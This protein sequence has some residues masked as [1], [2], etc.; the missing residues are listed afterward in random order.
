VLRSVIPRN[1][2]C[3]NSISDDDQDPERDQDQNP[4]SSHLKLDVAVEL[5][6]P[7]VTSEIELQMWKLFHNR[8]HIRNTPS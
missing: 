7:N 8:E 3:G 2:E 4:E 6:S 1:E 5:N